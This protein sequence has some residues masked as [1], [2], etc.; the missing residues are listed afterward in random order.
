[1]AQAAPV[2]PAGPGQPAA[3]LGVFDALGMGWRLMM[4]DFWAL[5]L[6]A[7]VVMLI[8]MGASN[9][10]L[11][12]AVLVQPPL[13]AGL[14]W[15][16]TRKIDGAPV[17]VGDVFAGFQ[18]RFGQSVLAMLPLSLA[19]MVFGLAM[20]VVFLMTIFG[21]VAI[22]AGPHGGGEEA[23]ASEAIAA[24]VVLG[25]LAGGVILFVLLAAMLIFCLFFTFVIPAV[26]D[27]PESGW[28]AVRTS[29]RLVRGRFWS[30]L[31]LTILF[32]F[33]GIA[34]NLVGMVACCIGVF[35]TSPIVMVWEAAA[36]I[37]LYRSWT[38]RPLAQG[39]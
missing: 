9:F 6:P 34:A 7:F 24:V 36:I 38:D 2:L 13:W 31:G 20:M 5:W 18:Q 25:I 17:K 28:E 39:A 12:A 1:M 8:I 11:V 14:Y 4:S 37:Y 21:G 19:G 16:V 10:G 15:L 23:I 33:I 22:S 29:A 27:H 26:W 35:F 30:V 3:P 32:I